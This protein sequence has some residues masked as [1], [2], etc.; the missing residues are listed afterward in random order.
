MPG[1]LEPFF[2]FGGEREGD[3]GGERFVTFLIFARAELLVWFLNKAVVSVGLFM[4]AAAV[5]S[6]ELMFA[7]GAAAGGAK[8]K[9]CWV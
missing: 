5:R 6:N 1:F 2:L 8:G 7:K 3:V 9:V 4:L